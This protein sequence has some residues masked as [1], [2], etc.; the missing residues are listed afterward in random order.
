[1]FVRSETQPGSATEDIPAAAANPDEIDID[2]DGDDDE[3]EEE[4]TIEEQQVP[5]QVFGSLKK[6]E[7]DEEEAQ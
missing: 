2:Q 7:E 4:A 1:M 6:D 3:E 5:R